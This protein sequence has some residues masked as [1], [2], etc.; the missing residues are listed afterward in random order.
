MSVPPLLV[1]ILGAGVMGGN[2][3]RT[4]A[5]LPGAKLHRIFD[6]HADRAA[7]LA[8][9]TGGERPPLSIPL[10]PGRMPW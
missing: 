6:S 3:A 9:Q 7:A 2:H 5:A 8:A 10:S 1:S 4:L